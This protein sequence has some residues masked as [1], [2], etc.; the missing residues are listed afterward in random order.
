M[1]LPPRRLYFDRIENLKA[2]VL[3]GVG[4][5]IVTHKFS[6]DVQRGDDKVRGSN[7]QMK[8]QEQVPL[9]VKEIRDLSLRDVVCGVYRND[10]K[11]L[12]SRHKNTYAVKKK[13]MQIV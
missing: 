7:E 5:G 11:V 6:N 13:E 3:I 2:K 8:G 9:V 10:G 1:S 12:Q 4:K